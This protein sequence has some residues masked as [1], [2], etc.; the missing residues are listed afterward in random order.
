MTGSHEKEPFPPRWAFF[1]VFLMIIAGI[2]WN[3][4]LQ[5]SAT[6]DKNTAQANSQTLAQDIQRVCQAQGKLL[7]EDRDLCAKAEK[8][9][10]NPTQAI[11]G[12]KG[13]PGNEGQP[14]KTGATGLTGA[15]GDKG[16]TGPVGPKGDKGDHGTAGTD[17]TGV[18]AAGKD[19]AN[20]TPGPAGPAGNDGAPGAAGKDGATGPTG[21]PGPPG[22]PGPQGTDGR[23]IQSAVCGDNG[24]WTITYTDGAVSDGGPCRSPGVLP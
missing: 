8:V 4:Y 7:I 15:K 20:G 23:G 14:G 13:Q 2:G 16:D 3:T 1:V 12:A 17:A 24:R 9:Q 21:P 10:D 18:G 11:P 22:P 6:L 5:Y 19:G